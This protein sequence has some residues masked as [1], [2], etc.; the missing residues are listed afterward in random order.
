M[1]NSRRQAVHKP[2]KEPSQGPPPAGVPIWRYLLGL[3]LAVFVAFEIYSPAING[4]FLFD[5]TYLPFLAPG[6]TNLP[7]WNW[8]RGV[9]PAL[10]LTFWANYH[11]F[12][13]DPYYF[14]LAN[15]L[16][17]I[18]NSVLAF[19]IFRRLLGKLETDAWKRTTLSVFAGCLYLFHPLQ[20]ESVSYVASRSETLSIFFFYAAY[21]L[22]L[23]RRSDAIRVLESIAVLVLFGAACLTKEHAAVLP[24]LLILTDYY[25]N[26]GFGFRGIWRNWKLYIPIIA[27]GAAGVFY[28]LREI[29]DADSAGFGMKDLPWTHYFFTQC[30][31]I[32]VY[33]RMFLLP[34]GQN[35]DHDF[36][37]SRSLLD[38]GAI[39]GM[40]ALVAVAVLAWVY[41][42]RFPLA[43]FGYFAFL[44]LLAPTSSFVP[45]RDTLVE[46][47]VYLPMIGLLLVAVEFL[48]RLR[49]SRVRLVASLGVVLMITAGLTW[50]RNQVWA[51]SINLWKDSV[52]KAPNRSRPRFQLA[53]AHYADGRCGDAAREYEIAARLDP[54]DYRL[55]LD[56]GLALDCAGRPG[57]A[58]GK[59]EEAARKEATAHVYSLIGM[60]RGKQGQREEAFNALAQAIRI[61]RGFG[62]AYLY[63]GNVYMSAGEPEKA[64][65]DYARAIR[66]MA[67][68]QVAREALA[69]AQAAIRRR[70]VKAN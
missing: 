3:F 4:P 60:V 12:G 24:G 43:S 50:R 70:Q 57:D 65:E 37:T 53:Y 28:I 10:M 58:L 42:K 26:P 19:L 61:D 25:F 54:P 33:V 8:I 27:G 35:I 30:R 32:W 38:H 67:E 63:R 59:L 48:S 6:F 21:T 56:W 51:N 52:S 14:H 66:R 15:V 13:L 9:R 20:T 7:L 41:R 22:F 40:A 16:L 5:D 62:L 39:I 44:L 11:L 23:Y 2:G 18:L 64:A 69:K 45:I 17:H 36:A 31:A 34:Y 29:R 55:L 1:K 47:R 49:F 68:N 46:R